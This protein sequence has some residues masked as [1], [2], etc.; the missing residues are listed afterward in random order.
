MGPVLLA[1]EAADRMQ[2]SGTPGTIVLISTMQAVSVFPGSTAY[3]AQKAALVHAAKVLAKEMRGRTNIRVNV[4]CPGNIVTDM[5]LSV[6]I[7]QAK[8]DG[9]PVEEALEKARQNYGVPA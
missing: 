4:I 7:A 6:E 1:R 3:A 2:R 9:T 5:K 8:R